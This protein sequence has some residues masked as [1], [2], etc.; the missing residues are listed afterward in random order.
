M[1]QTCHV[2]DKKNS[3]SASLDIPIDKAIGITTTVPIEIIFAA[4]YVPVDLNNIFICNEDPYGMVEDAETMGLPRNTCSWIKG[5]YTATKNMG[6]RRVIGVVQGDC[7]HTNAL[8]E[9]FHSEG[10]EVIPFAYPDKGDKKL[11]EQQLVGLAKVL[12]VE[13]H[14]AQEMKVRLDKIR[15]IIHEIDRLTWEEGKVSGEENH[16]WNVSTSDMMG[17]CELYERKAAE[18][19]NSAIRR[20]PTKPS[21]LEEVRIGFI[22]VPP[23]CTDLYAFMESLGVHVVF[24]E[25]QRQFSMPFATEDLI[26]QYASYT[27]PYSIFCRLDDIKREI[28]RRDICGVIHYVQSFCFRNIQEKIIRPVLSEANAANVGVPMLTLECDR[29]GRLDGAM[30]TRI[31]AF[32]EMLKES[33]VWES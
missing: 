9:V 27:Y 20:T 1:K 32:I 8:M 14:K 3:F 26:E 22:G 11:L 33:R 12:G 5:I 19:L 13:F 6:I 30:K 2:K 25:V 10:I 4:G 24:N 29:P 18:F 31:E 15:R 21:P 7:S 28:K 17:N 16:Y 23:I